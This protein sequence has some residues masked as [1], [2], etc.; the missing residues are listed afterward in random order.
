M[1]KAAS[2][3]SLVLENIYFTPRRA[4]RVHLAGLR[5]FARSAGLP[6]DMV[7][8]IPKDPRPA[9]SHFDINPIL[10]TFV[11]C[12]TCHCLYPYNLDGAPSGNLHPTVSHC[13]FVKTP[14]SVPCNTPLWTERVLGG[15]RIRSSPCAKYLH[16]DL[17]SWLGRLISRKGMEDTLDSCPQG[18]RGNPHAPIDD[19]WQSPVFNNLKDKHGT[20]FLPGPQNEGR[21][22]FGFSVDSFD[23]FGMKT[24]KQSVSSTGIWIFCVNLPPHLRFLQENM[25]LVGVIQGPHKPSKDEINPYIQLVV[26]D[27][28]DFWDPGVFFSRTY[29]YRFG[30][31]YK[32][33]LVPVIADMLALR[34]ILGLPGASKA[35]YFCTFCDL[36]I[37]DIDVLD[38]SEWP[39]KDVNLIRMFAKLWKDAQSEHDQMSIFQACGLRWSPLLELPYFN[40]VLYAVIDSVHDLELNLL[41]YH[42]RRLF[43]IDVKVKVGGDGVVT[44]PSPPRTARTASKK[45]LDFCRN[46]IWK[47]E[48][49]LFYQLLELHRSVLHG[50]CKAEGVRGE[51]HKLVVG[52][53]IVLA[54]NICFWVSHGDSCHSTRV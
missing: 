27:L 21:I 19:I 22:I 12:P 20:P 34:Q 45:E 42:N 24:A 32:G 15:G 46:L 16:Q 18:D 33:M 25:L 5:S 38:R 29:M 51:G 23:P 4:L 17:K 54:K 30:R 3:V 13:S 6:S 50:F 40:P 53:K 28:Q 7:N 9:S 35:H 47:N 26:N 10:R 8:L 14:S 52:T 36:D 39:K 2:L 41:P 49:R 48:P 11:S 43:Q 1:V 31:L 44:R 37:D